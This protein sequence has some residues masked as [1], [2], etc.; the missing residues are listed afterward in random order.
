MLVDSA[1]QADETFMDEEEV[2]H[3][4][5]ADIIDSLEKETEA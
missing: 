3:P 5:Y 2:L 4:R 1:S